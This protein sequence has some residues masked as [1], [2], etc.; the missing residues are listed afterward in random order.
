ME[1][2]PASIIEAIAFFLN[3]L[4]LPKNPP[5]PVEFSFPSHCSSWLLSHGVMCQRQMWRWKVTIGDG[6]DDVGNKC[7]QIDSSLTAWSGLSLGRREVWPKSRRVSQCR[8]L[9]ICSSETGRIER[10]EVSGRFKLIS[11]NVLI[12][13]S[14]RST[15]HD[16]WVVEDFQS[17]SSGSGEDLWH[18]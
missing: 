4:S 10:M 13:L 18:S 1:S 14:G 8:H 6:E 16:L 11:H 15:T 9:W 3:S 7:V 12:P 2:T 17:F 5:S